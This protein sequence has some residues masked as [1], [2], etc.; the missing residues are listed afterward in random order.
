MGLWRKVAARIYTNNFYHMIRAQMK[1][2]H[3]KSTLGMEPDLKMMKNKQ[4]IE[5]ANRSH[6]TTSSIANS[7]HIKVYAFSILSFMVEKHNIYIYIK[8]ILYILHLDI[9]SHLCITCV[10]CNM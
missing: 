8:C 1:R 10:T 5:D 7:D 4:D 9:M 6:S 3:N 2:H